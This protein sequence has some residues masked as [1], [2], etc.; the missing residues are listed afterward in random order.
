MVYSG[1]EKKGGYV[2]SNLEQKLVITYHYNNLSHQKSLE[3]HLHLRP[4]MI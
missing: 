2:V 1:Q 3:T 4:K